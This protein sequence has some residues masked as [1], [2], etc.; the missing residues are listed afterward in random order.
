M[1]RPGTATRRRALARL[2]TLPLLVELPGAHATTPRTT[3]WE[4]LVPPGWDPME[5]LRDRPLDLL[6]DADPRAQELM[7]ALR[8]RW[9]EA[10]TRPELAGQWLR[11]PG[12]V[13]PIEMDR[14][15]VREC[16][17]VPYFGACIHSPP[18]PANQIIRVRLAKPQKLRSMDAVWA[19][20]RLGLERQ[21]S[22]LGSSGYCMDEAQTQPY[23]ERR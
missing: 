19:S 16:L 22:A 21:D 15:A 3:T 1:S 12:Y 4:E 10:P 14:Q 17:L 7:Q 8:K 23:R 2:L 9:D 18:P 13:V 6:S 11:L 20:G 5:G